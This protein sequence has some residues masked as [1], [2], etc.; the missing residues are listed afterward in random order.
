MRKLMLFMVALTLVA[1]SS[2]AATTSCSD[3]YAGGL[4]PVINNPKMAVKTRELC[5][6]GY[7]LIHSG[8]TRTPLVGGEYLTR[9]RLEQGKG[10]PRVN[11]FRPDLR[12]P[13]S[14][15][16]ELKDYA[17][18]GY[19]RGHL[20][21][22]SA[23]AFSPESQNDTFLLSN[24]IPQDPDNNRHLHE[25][26]ESAVRNEAKKRG[27]LYVVTGVLFQ[28]DE[29]QSLKGRVIIPSV[30]YKCIY[31][32]HKQESGCYVEKNVPGMSYTVASVSEVESISGINLYP[33][34]PDRVKLRAMRLPEPRP[35]R[36]GR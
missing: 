34:V 20:V 35:Y 36:G 29:L 28:G 24:M 8:V 1:V 17:R 32:P 19:D 33:A 6:Q 3:N 5:N 16:S 30:L 25:G 18:S 12:L 10:L 31:D 9:E 27:E 14:E 4:A 23:D 21:S 15:R 2:A 7:G 26:I 13:A 11:S 22:P